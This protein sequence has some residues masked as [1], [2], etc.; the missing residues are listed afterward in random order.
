MKSKKS[1][2][3]VFL[4]LCSSL[5]TST[6]WAQLDSAKVNKITLGLNF[7]AHG[8]MCGGGLPKPSIQDNPMPEEDFSAFLFGRTR[9]SVSYERMWLE[10]KAVIQNKAVWGMKSNMSL[11]LY[12]G[13]VKMKAR[14]GLFTQLGRIA[15]SYDDERIIGTNDFATASLSHDVALLGYEGHRH[16]VHGLF[17]FNQNGENVY[18]GTYY[19]GGS[20]YYKTMQTLWYHYDV[21]KIPLGASLLFMNM[22][23][24]AGIPGDLNNPPSTQFQQIWGTYLNYHPKYLTLEASYYRQTG[25]IVNDEKYSRPIRAWMASAKATIKPTDHY[26]FELG[27]DYLSGD[28]F[29]PMTYGGTVGLPLHS[30]EGGFAPLYGSRTKFYGIMDYFYESAY[31]N[32][33]TP[34]LQ[35]AFVSVIGKPIPKLSGRIAYHYLAVTTNLINLSNTLGHSIDLNAKYDFSKDISLMAGYTLMTGTETMNRLKQGS[36]SKH[37]HWG[38]FSLVVSPTFFTTMF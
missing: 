20:Q 28:D 37:A 21:S 3:A 35:N 2:A 1:A 31:I 24:Q 4:F 15:L 8:E 32:G 16:K 10:A 19:D 7:L 9:L 13:W 23:I 34:G 36:G 18:A 30:V 11:N 6:C 17:A 38:W 22:G 12:E 27:Y 14:N 33:F 25:K 5:F 26:G 29:V